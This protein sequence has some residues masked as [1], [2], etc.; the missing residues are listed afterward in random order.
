MLTGIRRAFNDGQLK[1]MLIVTA[2]IVI[3]TMAMYIL[4]YPGWL[5]PD[6]QASIM[7][8]VAGTPD[9][10]HSLLWTLV[11]YPFIYLSPSFGLYGILQLSVFI[12]CCLYSICRLRKINV[13]KDKAT[14]VLAIVYGLSPTFLLYNQFWCSDI[15]FCSATMIL[16]TGLIEI[17][18]SKGMCLTRKPFLAGFIFNLYIVIEMRKNA[19]LIPIALFLILFFGYKTYRKRIVVAFTVL[20]ACYLFT[21]LFFSAGLHAAPS[22]KYEITAPASNMIARAIVDDGYIPDN[23]KKDLIKIRPLSEWKSIYQRP[24]ADSEKGG[25]SLNPTFIKDFLVVCTLNPRS[26]LSGWNDIIWP[27]YTLSTNAL[28]PLRVNSIQE[29]KAIQLT[30]H[31]CKIAKCK[32]GYADEVSS[33]SSIKEKT[34]KFDAWINDN[35]I[36]LLTDAWN[37]IFFNN[38]LPLWICLILP[39]MVFL[40]KKKKDVGKVLIALTPMI[41]IV[42]SLLVFSSTSVFRYSLQGY[43]MIPIAIAYC[44]YLLK[45][46]SRKLMEKSKR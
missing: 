31:G 44:I 46:N 43:Y 9:E 24:I 37:L 22:P 26:C 32:A 23:I 13:I 19:I 14:I 4:Y 39:L 8:L 25:T 27:Y 33:T 42:I 41:M 6:H 35:H 28:D 1:I 10:L 21:G 30:P 40:G 12:G 16:I 15:I 2:I 3:P 29:F 34:I 17:V 38:A 36:F 7:N 5:Q 20:T 45:N 11:S 18:E